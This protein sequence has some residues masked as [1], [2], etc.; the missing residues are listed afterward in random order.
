MSRALFLYLLAL[1]ICS[2]A[3]LVS[4]RARAE[5]CE[6]GVVNPGAHRIEVERR[7]GA[8]TLKDAWPDAVLPGYG[9]ISRTDVWFYNR[10]SNR[11]TRL[12]YFRNGRLEKIRTG[13]FGYDGMPSYP[14]DPA[15]I[16]PGMNEFD[17]LFRCGQPVERDRQFDVLL[18][19]GSAPGWRWRAPPL[20]Q[21]RR[22]E[23]WAYD[24]G[25]NRFMRFVT[26]VDGHVAKVRTGGRGMR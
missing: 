6:G 1:L 20:V 21:P 13:G 2:I 4:L 5:L 11:L 18:L 3:L 9:V 19:P 17:L 26:V 15:V 7:C 25:D 24:F 16:H 10:G 23:V 14:C 12:F 22:V 8:P